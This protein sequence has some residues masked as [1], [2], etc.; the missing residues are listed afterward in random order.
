MFRIKTIGW[1]ILVCLSGSH[2]I[3]HGLEETSA[4]VIVRDGQVEVHVIV[5]WPHWQQALSDEQ[6]WLLGEIDIAMSRDDW[7]SPHADEGLLDKLADATTL[8][9]NGMTYDLTALGHAWIEGNRVVE[10]RLSA[11]HQQGRIDSLSV[12][13]PPSLGDVYL[14]VSRPQYRMQPAGQPVTFSLP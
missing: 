7:A 5:D 2:A 14:S 3:A 1:L 6:A 10:I 11:T 8:E 13:L 12:A 4:Q 9:L